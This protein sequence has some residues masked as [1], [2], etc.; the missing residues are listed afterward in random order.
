[1]LD[2]RGHVADLKPF[3]SFDRFFILASTMMKR[4]SVTWQKARVTDQ[5]TPV[6]M[7]FLSLRVA[8]RVGS[9]AYFPVGV[10][11]D[12]PFVS[13]FWIGYQGPGWK[14]LSWMVPTCASAE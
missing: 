2:V 11:Q 5:E 12:V 10:A 6:F 7:A 3:S 1:M 14:P 9:R 8:G 4:S 13:L